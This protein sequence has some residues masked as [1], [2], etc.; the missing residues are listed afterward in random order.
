MSNWAAIHLKES[1]IKT[2]V[3]EALWYFFTY[4]DLNFPHHNF[5]NIVT[6]YI[7]EQEK[8]RNKKKEL[9]SAIVHRGC[10]LCL[11]GI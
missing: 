1:L 2:T 7:M 6:R 3:L 10:Y 4:I 8:R 5:F 11:W 9:H